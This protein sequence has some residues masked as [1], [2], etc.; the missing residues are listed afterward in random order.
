MVKTVIMLWLNGYGYAIL[1]PP[2]SSSYDN[3]SI[4]MFRNAKEAV[5]K[6]IVCLL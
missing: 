4:P 3:V 5:L 6:S 1:M 2:S